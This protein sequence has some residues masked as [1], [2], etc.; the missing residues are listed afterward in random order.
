MMGGPH[1][2]PVGDGLI[3]GMKRASDKLSLADPEQVTIPVRAN[4]IPG[5]EQVTKSTLASDTGVIQNPT[6]TPSINPLSNPLSPGPERERG[7]EN[8]FLGVTE[9][10]NELIKKAF[11]DFQG[12]HKWDTWPGMRSHYRKNPGDFQ[13]DVGGWIQ[14]KAETE[15]KQRERAEQERLDAAAAAEAAAARQEAAALRPTPPPPKLIVADPCIQCGQPWTTDQ[16][17]LAGFVR[18]KAGG[19]KVK[20]LCAD[21]ET[22]APKGA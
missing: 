9:S 7:E 4:D 16:S 20:K 22:P 3:P 5:S 6:V 18:Y 19:R 8:K 11:D 17:R 12:I 2:W 10:G 14:A 15:A 13:D 21:C 1:G